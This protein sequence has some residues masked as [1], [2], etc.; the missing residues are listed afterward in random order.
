MQGH[1]NSDLAS[2]SD[3]TPA[4][5]TI[6]V[7][8]GTDWVAES[9]ATARASLGLTIGT[10][11]QAWDADLDT[12]A[13]LAKT[14]GN[15]I[16]GDGAAWVAESG[17]TARTSLG[18]G[19]IATQSAASVAITGGSITG[20]TDLA[21]ADGGTGAG[22]AADARTNLGLVI[23]TN[24]Q[25]FD[26]DLSALA[27]LATAGIL[28]R[29]GAGTAA[30]RTITEGTGITV[31]NGDG[32]AGNPTITATLT[33]TVAQIVTDFDGAVATGTA[34]IPFDDTI[35]DQSLSEGDEYMSAT[36][37]PTSATSTLLIFAV[38]NFSSSTTGHMT[39]ALFQDSTAAAL[40]ANTHRVD[41]VAA[42]APSILIHSMAAGTTSATTFALRAGSNGAGTTTF[43]GVTGAQRFGGAMGSA[44]IVIEVKP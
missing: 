25:A 22:T 36:I 7:G 43:N 27:A 9:G 28:A 29:T 40:K 13:G 14:D 23:G 35:P 12:L 42:V 3:L 21:V 8:D 41:V 30:A 20:I 6:I 18:L 11:V 26:A 16:V 34:L 24:V 44:F 5:G 2:I 19:T 1:L 4:D 17:A 39:L 33:G 37:T 32:A 38:L 10:N 15:I 31:A